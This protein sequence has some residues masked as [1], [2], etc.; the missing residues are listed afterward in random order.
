MS[1]KSPCSSFLSA[2]PATCLVD[3]HVW[4]KE[5]NC[6]SWSVKHLLSATLSLSPDHSCFSKA[7]GMRQQGS[8][9]KWVLNSWYVPFLLCF[10][11]SYTFQQWSLPLTYKVQKAHS[12]Q[13]P[14]NPQSQQIQQD[15]QP[16]LSSK[17]FLPFP[18]PEILGEQL[19]DD[20]NEGDSKNSA[21]VDPCYARCCKIRA[22]F[23]KY[24]NPDAIKE[25][26]LKDQAIWLGKWFA[27]HYAA[28]VLESEMREL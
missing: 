22:K 28:W 18:N 7:F 6:M 11:H 23:S 25:L 27:H 19:E 13:H 4:K 26:G 14:P 20:F 12:L 21:K 24:Y 16:T 5:E 10:A 8:K 17:K 1:T 15:P 2:I 3:E 9:E